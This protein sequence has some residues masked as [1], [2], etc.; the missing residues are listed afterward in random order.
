MMDEAEDAIPKSRTI[1]TLREGV[2]EPLPLRVVW[3]NVLDSGLPESV[4]NLGASQPAIC[5]A[6]RL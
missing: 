6:Q 1:L 4:A 3:I 2:M 5:I